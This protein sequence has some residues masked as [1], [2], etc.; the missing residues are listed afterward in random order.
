MPL[1]ELQWIQIW[2]QFH[3][4]RIIVFYSDA[5]LCFFHPMKV[6]VSVYDVWT[7]V[8]LHVAVNEL[9]YDID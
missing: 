5:P 2:F 9:I 3:N 6:C 7:I 4:F 1:I 8:L